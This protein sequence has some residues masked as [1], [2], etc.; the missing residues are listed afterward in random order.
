[1]RCK[2]LNMTKLKKIFIQISFFYSLLFSNGPFSIETITQ[3]DGLR[4]GPD[5]S[6]ALVYYPLNA[7]IPLP[8]VVLVPGFTNSIS[9]I[10]NWGYYLASY[11]FVIFLVNVNSIWEPPS[12]RAAAL[13]DGIVTMK[14]ENERL[15]SPLF[16]SLNIADF[17][18]GGYSMGG[19]GAQLAAQQDSSIKAVIALSPWLESPD[20]T[21]NNSTSILFISG[22]FD[23]VAPNDYHTNVF[24]N[25]TPETTDKLLYE[26]SGGDHYT[27]VSPYSDQ[28]MGLKTVFWLEKYILN[29]LSN[30][31]SL[32][33]Q[34]STASDF[35][36]N[37]ECPSNIVGDIT[38]DGSINFLDLVLL[39][40]WI[41]NGNIPSDLEIFLA[42]MTN[43]GVLDIFDILILT[44]II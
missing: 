27:V 3:Q 23:T 44:D 32:I 22:E 38:Q 2:K 31:D 37:I 5:Y 42:D 14:L 35:S 16:G 34:P 17:T 21:L 20:A 13:L 40:S 15:N 12:Y 36:T 26:I 33:I 4:D 10:E 30:C 24:Y 6:E 18:V 25:N 39:I 11:G 43:D 29:D 7:P 1:M 28:E 41:I 8:V 9:D 19:G